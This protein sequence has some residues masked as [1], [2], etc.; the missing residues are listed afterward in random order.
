MLSRIFCLC[1]R[2]IW[3]SLGISLSCSLVSGV[4]YCKSFETVILLTIL[5]PVES[6]VASALSYTPLLYYFD[7]ISKCLVFLLAIYIFLGI[8]LSCSFVTFSDLF[9]CEF[10]ETF[11]ILSVTLLLIKSQVVSAVFLNCFFRSSLKRI[12]CRFFSMINNFL[13]IFTTYVFT[14]IFTNIF[15]HPIFLEK[16]RKP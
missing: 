13:A 14:D 16:C 9:C 5:L 15:T 3:F 8:A 4:F 10:L 2:D 11:V 1:S 6:L 12:C 7:R